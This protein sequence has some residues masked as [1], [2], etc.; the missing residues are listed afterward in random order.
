VNKTGEL[1]S[2]ELYDLLREMFGIGDYD[3]VA[4]TRP[5]H[6]VRAIEVGKLNR[7]LKARHCTPDEVYLAARYAQQRRT[8]ITATWQVFELV[9][10]ALKAHRL[11]REAT[12]LT[13][14]HEQVWQATRDALA[15][16][17]TEWADRL[18]RTPDTHAEQVLQEWRN[19]AH[20]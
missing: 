1:T 14:L 13:A 9:P 15:A 6:R 4:T 18:T 12:R 11:E 7:M 19:H 2:G 3:P 8:P 10:E 17:E 16:G 5:W 20:Q